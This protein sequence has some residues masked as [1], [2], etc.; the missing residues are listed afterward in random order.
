M[1]EQN[2]EQ[3]KALLEQLDYDWGCGPYEEALPDADQLRTLNA[4][5][6]RSWTAED[7]REICFLYGSH[8]ST[9]ETVYYLFRGAYPPVTDV[10]LIFYRLKPGAAPDQKTVYE[11][12]RLGGQMETLES[13]P[14]TGVTEALRSVPGFQEHPW[15]RDGYRSDQTH[16]VR[17]DCLDQPDHWSDVHFWAFWYGGRENPEPDHM[18]RL[19]CHNMAEAQVNILTDL[20][21]SF[22]IPLQYREEDHGR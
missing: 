22:G 17:F 5:T 15:A 7:I 19:S 13:L 9:E 21:A 11:T 14:R 16:S 2:Y 10:D 1:N 6:G 12:Y 8:N 3:V 20:L 18:L 4:L